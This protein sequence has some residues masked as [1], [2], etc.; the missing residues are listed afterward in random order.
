M[1]FLTGFGIFAI[2]AGLLLSVLCLLGGDYPNLVLSIVFVVGAV[3]NSIYYRNR[4]K[5]NWLTAGQVLIFIWSVIGL[6]KF[7]YK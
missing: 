3:C 5:T 4:T 7:F 1:N 6:I 2:I